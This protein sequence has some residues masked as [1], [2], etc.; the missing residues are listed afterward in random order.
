MHT[1]ATILGHV[2]PDTLVQI[3]L[4]VAG[5]AWTAF[6]ASDW[7]KAHVKDAAYGKAVECLEAGVEKA[8]NVYV[9]AIKEA[10]A[11]GSL[12]AD[13]S[14]HA[15]QLAIDAAIEYGKSQGVDVVAVL[16]QHYID[17]LI[18]KIVD[19]VKG[20]KPATADQLAALVSYLETKPQV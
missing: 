4:A 17:V 6:R 1:I 20:P 8:F 13:E 16:G 3:A 18:Q 2:S 14:A 19:R 9:D 5:F 15:R 7:Y 12:T 11:D 10:R